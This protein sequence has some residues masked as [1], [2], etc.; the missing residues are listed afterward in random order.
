MEYINFQDGGGFSNGLVSKFEYNIEEAASRQ[1]VF[2]YQ[3]TKH[4]FSNSSTVFFLIN[5]HSPTSREATS[6]Q[7][8]FSFISPEAHSYKLM[9]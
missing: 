9:G 5:E 1:R 8:E 2:F 4:P 6:R 3:V 7:R